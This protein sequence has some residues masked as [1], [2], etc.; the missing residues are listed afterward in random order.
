MGLNLFS[1]FQIHLAN[2]DK[3]EFLL[4]YKL[5]LNPLVLDQMEFYRIENLIANFEEQLQ[6]ENKE[7]E[8]QQ[9][10]QE[11]QIQESKKSVKPVSTNYGGFS[12]PKMPVPKMNIPQISPPKF[13]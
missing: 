8:K 1:L 12:V 13:K 3:I 7:Y 6:K 2:W 4:M 10:D 5:Q 11:K 9:K